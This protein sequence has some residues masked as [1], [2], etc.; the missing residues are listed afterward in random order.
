[1]HP[2]HFGDYTLGPITF[3]TIKPLDAPLI[4]TRVHLKTSRRTHNMSMHASREFSPQTYACDSMICT[5]FQAQNI[6]HY[7]ET[8]I[9]F[10]IHN[11]HNDKTNENFKDRNLS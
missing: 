2:N 9:S 6:G 10:K 5:T 1:M 4:W 7:P 11:L 3:Y 8:A